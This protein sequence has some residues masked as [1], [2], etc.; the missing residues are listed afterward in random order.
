MQDPV[1]GEK[2]GAKCPQGE[3]SGGEFSRGE[4]SEGEN[5]CYP[6]GP[7]PLPH[8]PQPT[9]NSCVACDVVTHLIF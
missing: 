5:S 6:S 7:P 8:H 4:F 1:G 2:S 9:I 3:Y